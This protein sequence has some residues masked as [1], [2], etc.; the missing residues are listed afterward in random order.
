[1]KKS[2]NHVL[3]IYSSSWTINDFLNDVEYS[4]AKIVVNWYNNLR[5]TKKKKLCNE[6]IL[7]I[8]FVKLNKRIEEEF[9]ETKPNLG[10]KK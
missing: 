3:N 5:E 9:L 2:M 6:T 10:L 7:N 1:M 4:F 8:M